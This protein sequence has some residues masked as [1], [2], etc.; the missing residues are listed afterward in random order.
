[1]RLPPGTD[2]CTATSPRAAAT[3]PASAE[4]RE[5]EPVS[6]TTQPETASPPLRLLKPPER[7]NPPGGCSP[8]E[9][10]AV[11]GCCCEPP[12]PG[13]FPAAVWSTQTENKHLWRQTSQ[14]SPKL[15]LLSGCHRF[16]KPS[17]RPHPAKTTVSHLSRSPDPAASQHVAQP[18]WAPGEASAT[19]TAPIP[20]EHR[21]PGTS[22]PQ[23]LVLQ[24]KPR[25]CSASQ[26]LA[27]DLLR[28]WHQRT[29]EPC[30][31]TDLGFA[32][33]RSSSAQ[34]ANAETRSRRLSAAVSA[35]HTAV[36]P[37]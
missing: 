30:L 18:A 31:A 25:R 8:P 10:A 26:M 36:P 32:R 37:A 4:G 14:Y 28:H 9:G 13:T 33:L 12:A 11:S 24:R 20:N 3:A 17:L 5:P 1:M 23:H 16:T 15:S 22:L 2:L 29:P 19:V 34:R 6:Q 21:L 7:R 27:E 35:P